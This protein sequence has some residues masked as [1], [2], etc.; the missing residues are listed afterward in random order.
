[1]T[2]SECKCLS[3][4]ARFAAAIDGAQSS[5]YRPADSAGKT[6][7]HSMGEDPA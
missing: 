3:V 4:G 2:I 6:I 1:M 7:D 5:F